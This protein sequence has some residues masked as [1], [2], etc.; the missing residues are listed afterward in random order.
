MMQKP[1]TSNSYGG[2]KMVLKSKIWVIILF[3]SFFN[4]KLE[5]NRVLES[6]PWSFDKHLVAIQRYE[7]PMHVWDF[8]FKLVS[9]LGSSLRHSH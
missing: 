5:T 7:R 1:E 6:Q 9:F 3:S 4:I 8:C 2:L